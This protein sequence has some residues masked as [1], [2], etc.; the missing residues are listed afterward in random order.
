MKTLVTVEF[1]NSSYN[2]TTEVNPNCTDAEIK[3][4][5]VGAAFDVAG[6]FVRKEII[7]I[8]KS[9]SIKRIINI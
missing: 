1:S 6:I 9:V 5:F 8:C 7:K 2:Y 3:G 4:Y